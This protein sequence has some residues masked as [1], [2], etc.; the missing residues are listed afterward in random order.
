M[1]PGD[2]DSVGDSEEVL[3]SQFTD[4]ELVPVFVLELGRKVVVGVLY[5]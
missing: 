4:C 1:I 3:L 2:S 5:G